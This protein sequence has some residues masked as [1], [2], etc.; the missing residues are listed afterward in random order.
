VSRIGRARLQNASPADII[1]SDKSK[2]VAVLPLHGRQKRDRRQARYKTVRL[3]DGL[4]LHEM[5][6]MYSVYAAAPSILA[7]V[8]TIHLGLVVLRAHRSPAA[9]AYSF[10]TFVSVLFAG[11]PWLLSSLLGLVIGFVVH[12]G[13]FAACER[14]LPT[15]AAKTPKRAAAPASD[16][17]PR[18]AGMAQMARR[19]RDFVKTPVLAVFD[20]TPD[21]RTFRMARPEGFEFKAGQFLTIRVRADG[22][23][24]VR[25]Y[26]ISSPPGAQGHLEITVKRIGL[27]SGALHATVRPGAMVSVKAPAGAFFYPAGEDR[28]LVLIAGGVCITPLMSMLRHAIDAEPTRPVTLF[29][30]VRTVEDIAFADEI[31]MLARRHAQFQ[32]FIAISDG[33]A[34]PEFFPGRINEALLTTGAPDIVH[35]VC[36][37]CGPPPMLDATTGLLTKIG[38]PQPQISFEIFQAAVA[39]SAG[40]PPVA[41]ASPP[42]DVVRGLRF[43][44]SGSATTVDGDQTMLEAAEACGVAIPSLCR[45]GVCGT[46]RTQVLSGDVQCASRMLDEQDRQDGF[47]LACVTRIESDCTIDA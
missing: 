2:V 15:L 38:V 9:G 20:E 17:A 21:V 22:K 28:P 47:V 27:V 44:R 26:S 13:W 31:Q 43:E 36:L 25:C 18:P 4:K 29:Y 46:C 37:I 3:S 30:S 5:F 45:A 10:V 33:P 23:E 7:F 40:G 24:H 42:R 34:G 8:T 1:G 14:L 11:S 35:A 41:K 39:A 12:L 32:A 6:V 19:P 16:G